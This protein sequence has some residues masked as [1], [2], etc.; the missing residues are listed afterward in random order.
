MV[1]IEIVADIR[2]LACPSL[3]RLE[4]GFGL[5][6]VTVEVVELAQTPVG[7]AMAGISVGGIK[8]FVMFHVDEDVV[9]DA[10]F[11]QML[12]FCEQF[13]GGLGDHDVDTFADG[14]E[15]DGVVG[16][17]GSEDGNGIAG[18]EGIDGALVGFG[19]ALVVFGKA[20]EGSVETIVDVGDI[21]GQMLANGREFVSRGAHHRQSAYETSSTEVEQ[22][23][24]DDADLL[25][26]ARLS[27]A[28][29]A[30]G[31]LAGADHAD[32]Q[33]GH[34]DRPDVD[35]LVVDEGGNV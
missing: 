10:L 16:W 9:L 23:Q 6:H 15:G 13:D 2:V 5:G 32:I 21:L 29:E 7:G 12:M 28:D 30:R 19:V 1:R 35:E 8:A 17:V 18:G 24:A 27:A 20:V 25:V 3:E 33:R 11:Q 31:V 26:T 4:L 14:V 34:L 22:R